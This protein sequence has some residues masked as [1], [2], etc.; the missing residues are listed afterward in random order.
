[1]AAVQRVA[2]AGE[3]GGAGA[4]YLDFH[5]TT[6]L[7]VAGASRVTSFATEQVARFVNRK[8]G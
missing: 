4:A 5:P 1:M 3:V 8:Q 6:S 2:S 7:I